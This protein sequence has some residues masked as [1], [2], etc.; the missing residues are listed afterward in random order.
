MPIW[1]RQLKCYDGTDPDDYGQKIE[2]NG[3]VANEVLVDDND[4]AI[5]ALRMAIANSTSLSLEEHI[6]NKEMLCKINWIRVENNENKKSREELHDVL[7]R[8]FGYYF[9]KQYIKSLQKFYLSLGVDAIKHFFRQLAV[10]M[11]EEEDKQDLHMARDSTPIWTAVINRVEYISRCD[12]YLKQC[13]R[14]VQG[15]TIEYL[16]RVLLDRAS[17]RFKKPIEPLIGQLNHLL[18]KK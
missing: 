14:R 8:T 4:D 2:E 5:K 18:F 12:A 3:I 1:V 15:K 16:N 7:S 13:E 6:E 9:K 17:A 10:I 11:L